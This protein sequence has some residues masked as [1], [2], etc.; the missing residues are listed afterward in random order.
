MPQGI[1]IVNLTGVGVAGLSVYLIW[2]LASNELSHLTEAVNKLT[3]VITS[4]QEWLKEH[5]DK[6]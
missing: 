4:L 3:Q 2:K 5:H 6:A 1:D